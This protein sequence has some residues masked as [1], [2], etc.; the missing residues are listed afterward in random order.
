MTAADDDRD[1]RRQRAERRRRVI[2]ERAAAEIGEIAAVYRDLIRMTADQFMLGA[3]GIG[4][5]DRAAEKAEFAV[6]L[7]GHGAVFGKGH[8]IVAA[9]NIKG[10]AADRNRRVDGDLVCALPGHELQAHR[11]MQHAAARTRDRKRAAL[12]GDL[13]FGADSRIA[14]KNDPAARAAQ[15][16]DRRRDTAARAPCA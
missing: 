3:G 1:R 7:F 16:F 12:R 11:Q 13:R 6:V 10:S 4:I 2:A 9:E 14:D 8:V 5:E 15:F